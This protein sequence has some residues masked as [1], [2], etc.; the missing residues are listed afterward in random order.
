MAELLNTDALHHG[1]DQLPGWEGT[2]EG[3][4]KTYVFDDFAQALAFVNRVG[5]EAERV[6]H[7]PDITVRWNKVTLE[8]STHSAGGV[9][10]NDLDLAAKIEGLPTA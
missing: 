6:N 9:T 7:H 4:A 2:L 5:D 8:L 3:I 1:L 10:Q